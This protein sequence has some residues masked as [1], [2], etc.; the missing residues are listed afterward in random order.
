MDSSRICPRQYLVNFVA[1][2]IS[3]KGNKVMNLLILSCGT[4]NLLVR[5]F[6][7]ASFDRVIVTDCSELAPALYEAD[8]YYIVPRMDAP[9]YLPT[10][11][12]ICE[13]EKIN[14]ILPLQEDELTLL[15]RN[16]ELFE[17]KGITPIISEENT[18]EICRDKYKFYCHLKEAGIPVLAS[19][20]SLE[21]F[22]TDWKVQ[23]V[24]FPVFVKPIRGC[25]SIGAMKVSCM[26]V[27][28]VL[29]QHTDV[30][31]LIQEFCQGK[32]FGVDAYVDLISHEVTEVF[33]KEKLRMRAGETEKSVTVEEEAL[34]GLILQTLKTLHFAGP[35][36]IDVFEK[37]GEYYISEIN[38]RFGGGYPHAYACGMN[39]PRYLVNN[40]EGKTNENN[41]NVKREKHHVLKYSDVLVL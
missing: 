26:E 13:D 29:C 6:K 39:V 2:S 32:E 11:L 23:K 31:L 19:Y 10:L 38:P 5:Y 9:N 36:D 37:N 21:D 15:A 24:A 35:I 20:H 4:R 25:G 1:V 17:Q 18:L 27:L 12:A 22:Q 34:K 30:P 16:R 14:A 41:L 7:Q 40:I 3:L 28:E 33:I 8:K